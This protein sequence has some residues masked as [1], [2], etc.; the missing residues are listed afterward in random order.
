MRLSF[1]V[2]RRSNCFKK[3]YADQAIDVIKNLLT[4]CQIELLEMKETRVFFAQLIELYTDFIA[5]FYHQYLLSENILT[6]LDFFNNHEN[7]AVKIIGIKIW[8][9]LISKLSK[10]NLNV[11]QNSKIKRTHEQFKL[12]YLNV[13][14]GHHLKLFYEFIETTHKNSEF[15]QQKS[16]QNY[17]EELTGI[18]NDTIMFNY[19]GGLDQEDPDLSALPLVIPDKNFRQQKGIGRNQKKSVWHQIIVDRKILLA[20][21]DLL[22]TESGMRNACL[23]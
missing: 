21:F 19:F 7:I 2:T 12:N 6:G 1:Y 3:E 10:S 11:Q 14:L 5:I 23:N 4:M 9:N 8:R 15:K 16:I 13:I 22:S 17:W 20:A 18:L